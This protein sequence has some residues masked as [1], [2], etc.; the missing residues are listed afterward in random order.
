MSWLWARYAE[1]WSPVARAE[2][3]HNW[4]RLRERV[5]RGRATLPDASWRSVGLA[6]EWVEAVAR[7]AWTQD[8]K[9]VVHAGEV[10]WTGGV[11]AEVEE[12]WTRVLHQWRAVTDTVTTGV[13][14]VAVWDARP[15]QQTMVGWEW[16]VWL[17]TLARWGRVLQV[18]TQRAAA[19]S[20]VAAGDGLQ[21]ICYRG[22]RTTVPHEAVPYRGS[23]RHDAPGP[24][25]WRETLHHCRPTTSEE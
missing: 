5:L 4:D 3:Q 17:P 15:A 1:A 16:S 8:V 20:G 6:A 25:S 11:A 9:A 22:D 2:A 21:L 19:R 18:P 12:V 13:V 7:Y 10:T 23:A 14:E 24:A